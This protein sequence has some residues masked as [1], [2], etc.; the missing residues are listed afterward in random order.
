MLDKPLFSIITPV[1]NGSE[2]FEALILSVKDQEEQ[3]FEHIIINDGSSDEEIPRIIKKY[4]HLKA[5]SREN[6]GQYYSMNE[7][8]EKALGEWVCFISADDILSAGTL[9]EVKQA[10]KNDPALELVWGKGCSIRSDGSAYEIQQHFHRYV[11]LYPYLAHIPH[12]SIFVKKKFLE[13]NH[14]RFNTDFRYIADYIWIN[15]ILEKKPTKVFINQPL[16]KN[17]VHGGQTTNVHRS[18]MQE[19]KKLAANYIERNEFLYALS[20]FLLDVRGAWLR[21]WHRTRTEGLR[22][23]LEMARFFFKR[24]FGKG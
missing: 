14:L 7:G 8:L 9:R 3:D 6:K 17:R 20:Q 18:P 21:I 12:S 22:A 15:Q 23:G 19:E 1:Y 4:P 5:W 24:R 16:S 13:K 10:I 2:F 11:F